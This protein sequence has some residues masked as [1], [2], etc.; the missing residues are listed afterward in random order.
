MGTLLDMVT[1]AVASIRI[2]P[3][4]DRIE[5]TPLPG[6]T[7]AELD[8]V[9]ALPRR[10]YDV[11]RHIWS[12]PNARAAIAT[13][14]DTFGA[15]SVLV[16]AGLEMVTEGSPEPSNDVLERVRVALTVCRC[17]GNSLA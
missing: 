5:I 8:V 11:G 14:T 7:G 6:F 9:R 15:R 16:S 4:E 13:L 1:R 2:L 10:N 17:P 3:E 12:A